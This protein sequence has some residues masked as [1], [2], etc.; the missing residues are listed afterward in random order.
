MTSS[1]VGLGE[2]AQVEAEAAAIDVLD[3]ELDPLLPGDP[4]AALDLGPA[5]Q[6]GRTSWRRCWRGV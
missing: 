4:G 3:V 2:D 1:Q 6:P 5:G